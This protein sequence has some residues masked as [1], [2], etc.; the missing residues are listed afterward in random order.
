M[1]LGVSGLIQDEESLAILYK[2]HQI[3]DIIDVIVSEAY[4]YAV[5]SDKPR[6]LIMLT[7]A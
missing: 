3:G 6:Q 2:N 5:D 1:N 7:L 4:E